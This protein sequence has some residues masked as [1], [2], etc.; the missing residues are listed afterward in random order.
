MGAKTCMLTYS[1]AHPASILQS[2]PVLDRHA[3]LSLARKLFPGEK[4]EP[5]NDSWL[6]ETYPKKD[7]L[8]IASYPGLDI[9]IA[10]DFGLDRPSTLARHFID[11]ATHNTIHLHAMHSVVDWFACAKWENG[12]LQRALSLA[13]DQGIIED[14]G[15]RF[16]FEEPYWAGEHPP[17]A[18]EEDPGNYPL[19]L[20]PLELG[21]AALLDFFGFQIEGPLANISVDPEKIPLLKFKRSKPWWKRWLT[22]K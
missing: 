13:P 2:L 18:P 7:E 10:T 3:S 14:Q 15:S 6:Y 8:L 12:Q 17:L 16:A 4:L 11:D 5:Q 22:S 21:E 19:Q 20:H 9:V 1:N